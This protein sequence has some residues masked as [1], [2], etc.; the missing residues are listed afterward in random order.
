MKQN[1]SNI[2]FLRLV[3]W[4]FVAGFISTIIFHQVILWVLWHAGLAPFKPYVLTP[5]A[6][7]GIPSVIS[8]ALWGGV[9]GIFFSLV[10]TRFSTR[11][12]WA[13]AFGFG[14]IFPSLVALLIVLP[15]KG[16]PVGGGWHWPL[17]VTA[18]L[19]NGAWG[20]GTGAILKLVT[21][22]DRQSKAETTDRIV[23]VT[24]ED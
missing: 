19:I 5:V 4:G 2:S 13:T 21:S 10:Q 23:D 3:F 8:L 20:F 22:K 15:L 1:N 11:G 9:W 17:L 6:P 14:A 12:Y 7:L 24:Y 16:K 18:F